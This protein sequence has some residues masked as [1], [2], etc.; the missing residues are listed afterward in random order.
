M[1]SS[2]S[3]AHQGQQINE[4]TGYALSHSGKATAED[5]IYNPAAGPD[6]YTNARVHAKLTRYTEAAKQRYGDDYDPATEPLDTDIVM[7]LGSGKQHGRYWM[8]NSAIDPSSVPSLS[9]I[10]S[11]STSS[12]DIPIAPRQQSNSQMMQLF[13][14]TTVP[15]VVHLFTHVPCLCIVSTLWVYRTGWQSWRPGRRP[16]KRPIGGR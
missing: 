6:A 16:R 13:Q 7:R 15:F 2:Q 11:R 5:N 10:R 14:V 8:A 12:S 1:F 3:R 4:F 9:A